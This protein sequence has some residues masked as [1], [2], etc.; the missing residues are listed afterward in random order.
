MIKIPYGK[1]NFKEV[2]SGNFFYQ[3][4]TNYIK[5][6]EDFDSSYL[7]YLRP[8]RFGKSLMVSA[9]KYYYGLQFKDEFSALFGNLFIGKN[10][11]PLA[12]Q[13]LVL[14]FEFSGI[15]TTTGKSTIEGFLTNVHYWI[16]DFLVQYDMFFTPEQRDMILSKKQ[17]NTMLKAL[18][19]CHATNKIPHKIYILVDEYDHFANELI[20]FDFNF[21]A[22]SV[23]ENGFVRKFYETIK[24]AT[25]QGIVERLFITG[26]SPVTLDSMT[27]GFNIGTNISLRL[28]FHAMMGFEE[29]E[30]QGLLRAI[31]V[32]KNALSLI[33][34]DVRAFYDG[35]LFNVNAK[36]RIYNTDMVLYF[37]AYYQVEKKY[38]D[39]LLDSNIASDYSKIRNI[40]KIQHQ[41]ESHLK[42]LRIL[43]DTGEIPA[44]L[45]T[46]FSLKK[47]F[48]RDDLVSLLFYMG[49]LTIH[50]EELGRLL[51]SFP[52]YA[53]EELYAD[54][55]SP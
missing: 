28:A 37:A 43:T 17:P 33:L 44:Q 41:E 22:K 3:D 53:I 38:P 24:T 42:T 51:F 32:K 5:I 6:L 10:P 14:T 19:S 29:T 36:T 23:T 30:V 39:N 27:S 1:S 46:E 12:N 7:I 15:D 4:R 49:F 8:R 11:T 50:Y 40:F 25:W 21:F 34:N 20:S 48:N 2:I 31:G 55:L 45:T 47:K 13:Y 35:Y 26:V 54:Y 18:L 52:N 9:L 16:N